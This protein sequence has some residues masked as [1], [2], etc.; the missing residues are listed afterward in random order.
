MTAG[1]AL[2]HDRLAL[3][4]QRYTNARPRPRAVQFQGLPISV[5]I[6]PGQTRSGV[7]EGGAPWS[8][9]YKYPYGEVRGTRALSDGDPV[10][11]YLGPDPLQRT[12]YVVH[13]LRRDGSY[14]ED[15]VMLGFPSEGEA[16]ACYKSH[17][18]SWGFGSL[19]RMTVD[20]FRHGYLASNRKNR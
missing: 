14:D 19:D 11:V 20:Q 7:E 3:A 5:E 6:E 16:V 9:T 10:D 15:K 18:P 4:R 12:V 17:G 13:Q 8:K 1:Y 2:P